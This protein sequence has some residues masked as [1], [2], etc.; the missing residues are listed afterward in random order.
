MN[1]K[2]I[3]GKISTGKTTGYMFKEIKKIIEKNE[4]LLI[5]DNK[6]EYYKTF[7]KDLK[8]KGYEVYLIN[9]KNPVKSNG[10]NPLLMPYKYY[11][12]GN[13]DVAIK[14][15]N[16]F[17]IN[18]LKSDKVMDP[19]WINSASDYLSGIILTL[20]KEGKEKEINLGSVHMMI[21]NIEQNVEKFKNYVS[22]LD[23]LS[24]EYT[25]LSSTIFSPNE[26]RAGIVSVL[27]T[28]LTKYLSYENLFNLLC[29]NEIDFTNIKG[30]IAIFIIGNN[31]YNKLT[32]LVI[33][34]IIN[35]N[36]KFNYV[37]DNFDSLSRIEEFDDLLDDAKIKGNN[38]YVVSRNIENLYQN[39]NK[40]I[41][42]KFE[43]IENITDNISLEKIGNYEDYPELNN[44]KNIYF[45]IN[46]ILS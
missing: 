3:L 2:L 19:F 25:C 37:L 9:Y 13:K 33:S 24:P 43:L 17:S 22:L 46:K 16:N 40:L 39:Y 5:V 21:S 6:E 15:I 34:N 20:F 29:C 41:S 32:N 44:Q 10:F 27:K 45:D 42:D 7:A 30:K 26:T 28:G 8:D 38:V 18:L 1:T 11:K 36:E 14:L 23:I 12:S 31:D 35:S 4:N